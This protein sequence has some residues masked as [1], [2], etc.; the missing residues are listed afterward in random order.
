MTDMTDSQK[1]RA[2]YTE[3]DAPNLDSVLEWVRGM[4]YLMRQVS[5][6]FDD[7]VKAI[8]TA[9]GNLGKAKRMIIERRDVVQLELE[10]D[11]KETKTLVQ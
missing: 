11:G 7:A 6:T 1:L 8:D 3:T 10:K 5:L 9:G 2:I 4:K